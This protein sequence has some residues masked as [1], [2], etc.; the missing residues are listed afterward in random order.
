M[1]AVHAVQSELRTPAR[2]TAAAAAQETAS[3]PSHRSSCANGIDQFS[4]VNVGSSRSSGAGP[5][6]APTSDPSPWDHGQTRSPADPMATTLRH[7]ERQME[8]TTSATEWTLEA[9]NR[10]G[11]K[12]RQQRQRGHQK[13]RRCAPIH[14]TM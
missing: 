5:C 9:G 3:A 10:R 11:D 13:V 8:E 12:R 4:S 6:S 7:S 14:P 2:A 1:A